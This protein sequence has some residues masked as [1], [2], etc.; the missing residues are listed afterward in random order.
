MFIPGR[1]GL[2]TCNITPNALEWLKAYISP[3]TETGLSPYSMIIPDAAMPFSATPFQR[4]DLTIRF[5]FQSREIT[6]LTGRNYSMLV[7]QIPNF[8]NSLIVM[9]NKTG[10]EFTPEIVADLV[11]VLN[12]ADP[13]M[14][15]YPNF[16][17]GN[18]MSGGTPDNYVTSIQTTALESVPLPDDEGISPVISQLRMVFNGVTIGHN[19]PSL[20]DQATCNGMVIATRETPSSELDNDSAEIAYLRIYVGFNRNTGLSQ[21]GFQIVVNAFP[22]TVIQ[23][24]TFIPAIGG[25]GFS[26]TFTSTHTISTIEGN[27]IINIGD[28]YRYE[29]T[30]AG[31]I[32][33]R[34]LTD[35]GLFTTL[36]TFITGF[37]T[38]QNARLKHSLVES[39]DISG[40]FNPNFDLIVLPPIQQADI[41]QTVPGSTIFLMK[42]GGGCYMPTFKFQP[43]FTPSS[44]NFRRQ[45]FAV[46][47]TPGTDLLVPTG[48]IT[49][50]LD[51]NFGIG[52]INI[53]GMPYAAQPL[54]KLRRAHQI[55]PSS[56]SFFG[57]F[58][59]NNDTRDQ[60]AIDIADTMHE[61]QV[62]LHPATD[63]FLDTLVKTVGTA[64]NALPKVLNS[65]T[66]IAAAVQ[67]VCNTVANGVT[68][69]NFDNVISRGRMY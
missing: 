58:A 18:I 29:Q 51:S 44:V 20:F 37:P 10:S 55:I 35:I 9:G 21:E 65:A 45:R 25:A 26:P 15:L 36:A 24:T 32:V 52:V 69:R 5:P 38:V 27:T 50:H 28:E 64:I 17:T 40:E 53:Q 54:I 47:N 61:S 22:S 66:N 43:V 39:D 60:V 2:P 67:K 3:C 23:P 49:D 1:F 14:L 56:G 59:Y 30:T 33:L 46:L 6:D 62:H 31:S 12:T 11:N 19:T 48:G 4:A 41:S 63:N 57:M 8:R 34:N 7:L 42:D 13:A 16:L 68:R